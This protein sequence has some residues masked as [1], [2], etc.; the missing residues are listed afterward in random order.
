MNSYIKKIHAREILDSR[1]N[2]TVEVD[3]ILNSNN[4]GR[5]S[6]PSGASVGSREA[7]ELRDRDKHRY[8]GLGVLKA[9]KKINTIIQ[10]M[11]IGQNVFSQE[12]IDRIMIECDGT[13]DKSNLGANSILAVSLATAHAAANELR[14]PLFEYL[15]KDRTD[16]YKMPI[17][18]MNIINGG[19]HADNK[20]DI[21]EFM[22]VPIGM[23]NFSKALQCGSEIFHLLKEIL[24]NENLSY[25]VGDEGGFAPNISS[26]EYAIELILKAIEKSAYVAGKD[27]F[28][29]LDCASSEFYKN[30]C[31][32][33]SSENKILNSN[34]YIQYLHNLVNKYPIISIED[35]MSETDFEGWKSLTK[36]LGDKI[37][38]IGDDLFVTNIKFLAD[39]IKHKMANSILIKP[40]Q[41]GTLTET[42][43]TI[44]LAK[45]NNYIPMISHRSGETAD[46]TIVD[47]AIGT[48]IRQIKSG[49]LC[50]SERT[51][52]YNQLIRI[53][54][55]LDENV[56]YS[57]L[58]FFNKQKK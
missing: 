18:F 7:K 29:A 32:Y 22:I 9:I 43:D 38:L 40:N 39:G 17:P 14:Q 11:L 10:P 44:N 54:E 42:I 47:I 12:T 28:L 23:P 31:Y 45:I 56:E 52:K 51:E 25:N 21:Q 2:P 8:L 3:V 26:H 48:G 13:S 6:I 46:N 5:A 58:N 19:K 1:G 53:E 37:Q 35:A 20:L 4:Y 24:I 50:R 15:H 55:Y 16:A 27:V 36:I 34:D 30:N 57:G 33:L 41:I 49:S